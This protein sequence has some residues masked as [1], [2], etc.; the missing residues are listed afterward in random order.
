MMCETK[1][2]RI[3]IPGNHAVR[4]KHEKEPTLIRKWKFLSLN[5]NKN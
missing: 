5:L 2:H 1:V 4:D 3:T